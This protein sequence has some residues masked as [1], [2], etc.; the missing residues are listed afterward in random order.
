VK[1]YVEF[2]LVLAVCALVMTFLGKRSGSEG[3]EPM[4]VATLPTV[5]LPAVPLPAVTPPTTPIDGVLALNSVK[6]GDSLDDLEK[7]WG[8]P[9]FSWPKSNMVQW[10][11]RQGRFTRV[12]YRVDDS[13]DRFVIKVE[14]SGVLTRGSQRLVGF[15]DPKERMFSSLGEPDRVESGQFYYYPGVSLSSHELVGMITL[16]GEEK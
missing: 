4:P 14:A 1:R 9:D 5:T 2:I 6:I 11:P 8:P 15:G 16:E 3:A 7:A 10:E 13:G 12:V